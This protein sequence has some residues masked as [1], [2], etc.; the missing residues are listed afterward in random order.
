MDNCI[1]CKI[2]RGEIPSYTIYEDDLVK[3]FLDINPVTKG[4]TLI[5]PKNHYDSLI[6]IDSNTLLHIQNIAKELMN[7]YKEKLGAEGFT[8]VQNNGLGQEVKHY[9]L[10][11]IPRYQ[12]DGLKMEANGNETP[13]EEIFNLL[14]N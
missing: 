10:H 9:H 12:E 8:L 3:V 2:I 5:I 4:H 1:F 6:D 13:V 7:K 14:N 11:L